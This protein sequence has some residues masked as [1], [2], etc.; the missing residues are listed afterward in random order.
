MEKAVDVSAP[1]P[2]HLAELDQLYKSE[3]I[4]VAKRLALLE[5]NQKV[6]VRKDEALGALIQL[7]IFAGKAN[8]SVSL[9]ESRTFSIW[10]GGNAFNTGQAWA[11]AQLVRGLSSYN[12]KKY[13][14]A[15]T[16][17]QAALAPPANLRAEGQTARSIQIKYWI[18]CAYAK[19]GNKEK[20]MQTLNE[21]VTPEGENNQRGRRNRS[22]SEIQRYYVAKAQQ[23]LDPKADVK[24]VF[25]ELADTQTNTT[26][27]NSGNQDYQFIS[28]QRLPSRDN[29][30][31]PHYIAG[32]GYAALGNK[33]KAREAFN[34]ALALSP[35]YLSA[36]IELDQLNSLVD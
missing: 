10:E 26:S 35:D 17:F 3:G 36:K 29:Q 11:D 20:A 23:K 25:T 15:L 21:I 14:E 31:L 24:K 30:A 8:E 34:A 16:D 22:N 4:A 12:R 7:K 18:G 33:V 5:K 19:L 32:L 2:T 9:L 6:V 28:A 1:F 27:G 13:Q